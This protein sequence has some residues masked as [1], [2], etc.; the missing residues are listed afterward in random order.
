MRLFTKLRAEQISTVAYPI[1][2]VPVDD[3]TQLSTKQKVSMRGITDYKGPD[4][5]PNAVK[6]NFPQTVRAPDGT[7]RVV[8][9]QR[10]RDSALGFPGSQTERETYNPGKP[11]KTEREAEQVVITTRHRESYQ[12][13]KSELLLSPKVAERKDPEGPIV[14]DWYVTDY[15]IQTDK[16]IRK[17]YDNDTFSQ[18]FKASLGG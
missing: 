7:A 14:G 5:D 11:V 2:V 1:P 18:Y 10:E 9:N 15:D 4:E 17:V 12:S 16:V 3:K 6:E 13:P 8:Q